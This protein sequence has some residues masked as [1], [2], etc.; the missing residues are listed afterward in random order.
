Q[1]VTALAQALGGVSCGEESVGFEPV[2]SSAQIVQILGVGGAVGLLHRALANEVS[3]R[4]APAGRRAAG[5][6]FGPL[7][8]RSQPALPACRRDRM[9]AVILSLGVCRFLVYA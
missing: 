3:V 8:R 5:R 9:G 7:W 6:R 2:V 4:P 1:N